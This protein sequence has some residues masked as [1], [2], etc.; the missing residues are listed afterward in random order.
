MKV[1]HL[2]IFA[3]FLTSCASTTQYTKFTEL[4]ANDE[5]AQIYIIRKSLMATA[6]PYMIYKDGRMVGEL[7]PKSYLA[8]EIDQPGE[9]EIASFSPANQDVF[10]I[11]VQMGKTYYLKQRTKI[12]V[13]VPGNRLELMD[14]FEA[15]EA[16]GKLKAPRV[17]Y[18]R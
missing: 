10:T 14:P 5:V 6:I 16:L 15:E 1:F 13:L 11:D 17:N 8:L 12:G 9:V 4:E 2:F 7:G 3:I 18:T